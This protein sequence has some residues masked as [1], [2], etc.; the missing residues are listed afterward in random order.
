MEVLLC[1]VIAAVIAFRIKLVDGHLTNESTTVKYPEL[2]Q[3]T[4]LNVNSSLPAQ[5]LL[6]LIFMAEELRNG[7]IRVDDFFIY[8]DEQQ[9]GLI[10]QNFVHEN[11]IDASK[12]SSKDGPVV[13]GDLKTQGKVNLTFLLQ[14]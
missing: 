3:S 4:S 8:S 9:D 13:D 5:S 12:N 2:M 10:R 6:A 14:V 1:T 7:R 11:F